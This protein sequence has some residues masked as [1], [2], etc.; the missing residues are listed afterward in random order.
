MK[1]NYSGWGK[2]SRGIG[3]LNAVEYIDDPA[4][5]PILIGEPSYRQKL[6]ELLKEYPYNKFFKSLDDWA[7]KRKFLSG[8]QRQSIDKSYYSLANVL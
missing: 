4:G 1:K 8:K 5:K 6:S 2:A 7:K 3:I